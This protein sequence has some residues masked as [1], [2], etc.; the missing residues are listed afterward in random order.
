MQVRV[1]TWP[2]I[3]IVLLAA[4]LL[5]YG[6]AA[7]SLWGDEIFTAIFAAKPPSE[8]IA[9]TASDIHPPLY[10]LLAGSLSHT[11]LW[12]VGTPGAAADWLWRWPSALAGLLTVAAAYRLG[13][14]LGNH[15][16]GLL[17]A[18][19]L[20]IAPVAVKYGQEARMH[21]LFMLLST[22]STLALALALTSPPKRRKFWIAY[23]LLT[24]LTLYTM[25]FA[26]IIIAI[27]AIWV[28]SHVIRTTHY[29]LRT[30]HHAPR[31]TH[32]AIPTKHR[33]HLLTTWSLTL[34]IALLAYLP[35]WPVLLN[36][37]AYRASVGPVEGGVG[38]PW[39]FLPKVIEA[40]GPS[41]GGAWL[42]LGLY[43]GGLAAAWRRD[44]SL[45]LLGAAWVLLPMLLPIFLGDSRARQLRYAFVLPLYL[46]FVALAVD[47]V[48]VF[49]SKRLTTKTRS[50]EVSRRNINTSWPLRGL[51]VFVVIILVSL[52]LY[53]LFLVYGQRKPDWRGAAAMVAASAGPGDVVVAGP[54]WDDERFFGY[55]YPH[56]ERLMTP[57]GL[58]FRLPGLAADM[59]ESGGRLWLVT[60][61]RPPPSEDYVA[62]EFYGLTVLEQVEPNYDPVALIRI[63][64]DFCRQAARAAEAWAAEMEAGG[65][66]NPDP[67]SS[68]AAAYRCQGD[69]YAVVG[70]FE[71]ALKPYEQMV[72]SFSWADGY[73]LLAKTYLEVDNLPAAAAAF[74]QAVRLNPA[75]QGIPADE[76]A[77]LAAA[78]RWSEAIV[79]YEAIVE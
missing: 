36:I 20:A 64:A 4:V 78:E 59:A 45:A 12:P 25:Y 28:L 24:I 57:P 79:L 18:L 53:G 30:T 16:L 69:T 62:Y 21:A 22:A 32:Y 61:H 76:A 50:S 58:A 33:F 65:V 47:N 49:L 5:F 44:R 40:I 7:D 70:D 52:S 10:Y 63:G 66:L 31:T 67:R 11:P 68:R 38:S 43:L 54:L 15:R 56:R 3:A 42:F 26:F 39:A 41:G 23:T 37:L 72:E 55:Y 13:R 46:F 8:T 29:A 77:R 73:A 48:S 75:W 51:R 14:A 2:V 9:F 74:A 35:W 17:T 27:H 60:R 19:L 71:A 34:F 6:L 1:T